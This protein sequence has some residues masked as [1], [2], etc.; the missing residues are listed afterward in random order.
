MNTSSLNWR[1][2]LLKSNPFAYMTPPSQNEIVWAGMENLKQQFDQVFFEAK[3]TTSTQVVLNWGAYG[4]GKT[5]ASIY[6]SLPERFPSV[7]GNQVSGVVI[8][9]IRTPKDPTKPDLILYKDIIEAIRF[10]R[11]RQIVGKTI[12]TLGLEQARSTLQELTESEVLGQAIVLLGLEPNSKGDLEPLS[13]ITNPSEWHTLLESYFFSQNTKSDLK[14]L[15]LSR[16]IDTAQERFRILAALL[17]CMIGLKRGEDVSTYSRLVLWIDEMEDLIYFAT[18]QYRPF[19]QGLRELIDRLP[20]AFTLMMNFTLA[21]PEVFEDTTV[22]LGEALMERISRNIYF[23]E[24]NEADAA[25]YVRE[26]ISTFRLPS[27]SESFPQVSDVYPFS[28]TSLQHL[29]ALLP[30]RTPRELNKRCSEVITEALKRGVISGEG[31]GEI[32]S[33]FITQL[34]EEQMKHME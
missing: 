22:V 17:Q 33:E 28:N 14:K 23:K 30:R 29:I 25:L 11:L 20:N 18:K 13:S 26:M 2:A 19:T 12:T 15:R 1:Y 16:S 7:Q 6:Y 3:T 24:P 31:V 5:H 32:T 9:R 4:S 27:I 21:S 8:L 10:S 34:D